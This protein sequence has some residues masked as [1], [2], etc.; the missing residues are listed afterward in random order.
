MLLSDGEIKDLVVGGVLVD[1]TEEN[2]GPVTYDLRTR[3]FVGKGGRGSSSCVLEPG[4]STFVECVESVRLPNDLAARVMLRNSRIR[5]GLTLDAPLYFPGH[6]TIL[7][8]R[9][10]NVSGSQIA[11]DA[12]HGIAQVAFERVEKPVSRPYAG[13]FQDE[14]EFRGMGDYTQVYEGEIRQIEAKA[15]EIKGVEHRIYG[16]VMAIMAILAGVFT[17]VNVN[18]G[19]TGANSS[20]KSVIT[21]NL[22]TVGSFAALVALIVGVTDGKAKVARLAI[23]IALAA[24]S[25]A[26]AIAC[27]TLLP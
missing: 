17:L 2:I 8:Y 19:A 24:V 27:A 16:N 11:L 21:L 22:V 4:D 26:A 20:L 23:P 25:F 10:T 9:V 1:A 13:A 14:M 7:Y 15:D 6:G 5:E 18:V 3:R 12:D